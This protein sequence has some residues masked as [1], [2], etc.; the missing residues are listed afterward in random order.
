L[1]GGLVPSHP[2]AELVNGILPEVM[3][4]S[5]FPIVIPLLVGAVN[6]AATAVAGSATLGAFV[7]GGGSQP[8][9]FI[10]ALVTVILA[11]FAVRLLVKSVLRIGFLAVMVPVGMCACALYAIP[12]TRWILGWWAKV[13]GGL[14]VAQ[15]P[16][17]FA[18]SVGLGIFASAARATSARRSGRSASCSWRPICTT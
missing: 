1:L 13:W 9:P 4:V 12:A 3:A 6:R 10:G 16:S 7:G 17:V 15:I 8:D 18:L 2:L 5:A 14:L 11:F